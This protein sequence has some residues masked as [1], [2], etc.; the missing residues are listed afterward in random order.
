MVAWLQH[1]LKYAWGRWLRIIS[2]SMGR[3]TRYLPVLLL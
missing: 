2:L 3:L 1:S